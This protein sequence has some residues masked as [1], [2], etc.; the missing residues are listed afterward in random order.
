[1]VYHNYPLDYKPDWT[2]SSERYLQYAEVYKD[3]IQILLK[4][5]MKNPPMHDYSLAPILFLLRQYI[6]LQ[7]KGIILQIASSHEVIKK[8]DVLYLY[9]RAHQMIEERY[10]LDEL[11]VPNED[12]MKF[13]HSLGEFDRK[14]QAFRYPETSDGRDFF[15]G[16]L[17]MDP[18]LRD[19]IMSLPDLNGIAEKVI[20]DLEGIEGYLDIKK[21]NEQE[22]LAAR[23]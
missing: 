3:V 19:I 6:E 4:E 21:E 11:G 17:E 16:S 13:I 8:H 1:M 5:Y 18:W 23:P 9:E 14:A 10:G 22:S 7:L 20:G 12:A 2:P 15:D